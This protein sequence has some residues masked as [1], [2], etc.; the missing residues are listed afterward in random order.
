MALGRFAQF[1]AAST[2]VGEEIFWPGIL[3]LV[4]GVFALLVFSLTRVIK[5]VKCLRK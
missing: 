5:Y 2:R 4:G 3:I 1:F